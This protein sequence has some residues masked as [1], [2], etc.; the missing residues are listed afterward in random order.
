MDRI[1]QFECFDNRRQV[2]RIGIHF[3]AI[4]GLARSAMAA[5]VMGDAA[6]TARSQKKH[7]VFPCVRTKRPAM[8]EDHGL[9]RAPVFVVDSRAVFSRNRAHKIFS[10][11]FGLWKPKPPREWRRPSPTDPLDP[12]PADRIVMDHAVRTGGMW[13]FFTAKIVDT[14]KSAITASCTTKNGGSFCVGANAFSAGT[15]MKACT[16]PTNTLK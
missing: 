15:F 8:A 1:P 14:T 10:L 16:I 4:P 12:K 3:I 7:L 13:N 2:V 5:A 6:V 11:R 9:S